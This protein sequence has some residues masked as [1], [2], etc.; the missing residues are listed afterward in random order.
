APVSRTGTTAA[1]AAALGL[2]VAEAETLRTAFST[3]PTGDLRAYVKALRDSGCPPDLLRHLVLA[4]VAAQTRNVGDAL[5]RKQLTGPYWKVQKFDRGEIAQFAAQQKTQRALVRDLLAPD[6]PFE[7]SMETRLQAQR[8]ELAGISPVKLPQVQAL[9]DDY[10]ELLNDIYLEAGGSFSGGRL[11]LLPDDKKRLAY[12]QEQKWKDLQGILSPS[13]LHEYALRTSTL[14]TQMKLQITGF[15]A[16]EEEYR[17]LYGLVAS[18]SK[19]QPWHGQ[20][21][22]D[23]DYSQFS[24]EF[25]QA[26]AIFLSQLSPERAA[27]FKF[28]TDP[29]T[30]AAARFV[31][32][33]DLP[34]S[35]ARNLVASQTSSTQRA[36]EIRRNPTLSPEARTA[37]LEALAVDTRR[38]VASILGGESRVSLYERQGGGWLNY[39]TSTPPPP[40]SASSPAPPR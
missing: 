18:S 20:G 8:N 16:T 25:N 26:Q 3:L 9:L 13:E 40:A 29:T 1:Q 21:G 34:L 4:A 10:Q 22:T 7:T 28:A 37:E 31:A 30:S 23:F 39:L 11:I 36:V 6:D 19:L 12:L 32:Q 38:Q 15:N 5:A 33:L 24:K 2:S 35:S 14:A 27:D 17:A